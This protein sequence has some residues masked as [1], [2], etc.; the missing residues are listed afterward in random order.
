MLSAD[1]SFIRD[2]EGG[3]FS[4]EPRP[5]STAGIVVVV[6]VSNKRLVQYPSGT[7]SPSSERIHAR[8]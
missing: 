4:G 2:L 8:R 6:W 5:W 3:F 1:M 7:F